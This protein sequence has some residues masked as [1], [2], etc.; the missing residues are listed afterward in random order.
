MNSDGTEQQVCTLLQQAD[1]PGFYPLHSVWIHC[2]ST[3]Y[4]PHSNECGPW[5][6]LALTIMATHPSP[7]Q[8]ILQPLMHPNLAMISCTWIASSIVEKYIN[9]TLISH[10]TNLKQDIPFE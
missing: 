10:L 4:H 6:L 3:M 7:G 1:I 2:T 9:N 5:T 8:H